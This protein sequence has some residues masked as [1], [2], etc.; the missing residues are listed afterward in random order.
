MTLK[1]SLQESSSEGAKKSQVVFLTSATTVSFSRSFLVQLY[2]QYCV[3]VTG[4]VGDP[5]MGTDEDKDLYT[6]RGN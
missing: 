2:R 3:Q 4:V 1:D 5:G 6:T